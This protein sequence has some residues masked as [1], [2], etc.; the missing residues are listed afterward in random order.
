MQ[1]QW[2]ILFLLLYKTYTVLE[3][4]IKYT[5]MTV[6]G[7]SGFKF[8]HQKSVQQCCSARYES[9]CSMGCGKVHF[10]FHY[11]AVFC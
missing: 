3:K 7:C 1:Q 6:V 8:F 5:D 9:Y 2:K 4:Y 11:T 10:M